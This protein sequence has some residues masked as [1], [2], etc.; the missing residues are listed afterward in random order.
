MLYSA[1][2]LPDHVSFNE[3][4][5]L[6]PLSVAVHAC[7]RA[8]ITLG[9]KVL[10]CGAGSI[11]LVCMLTA[12]ACGASQIL[13]TGLIHPISF[14]VPHVTFSMI[15]I[16]ADID[17]GRLKVAK[18]LGASFTVKVT[19]RDG[20]V[21]ARE[22]EETLGCKPDRSMECSGAESSIATAIYVSICLVS[23]LAPPTRAYRGLRF[24]ALL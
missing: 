8:D 3:A 23:S 22:V 11:G 1:C 6:E 12:R 16:G 5:L 2:R 17:E 18:E 24:L 20:R 9:S 10:I 4:A 15:F 14:C 7:R 21:T 19:G 13:V